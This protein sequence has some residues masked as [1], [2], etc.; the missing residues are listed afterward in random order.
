M[1]NTK[2]T[3]VPG[4]TYDKVTVT[5]GA[6]EFQGDVSI[7][8]L[9]ALGGGETFD[10]ALSIG[11]SQISLTNTTLTLSQAPTVAAGVGLSLTN[12]TLAWPMTS[13]TMLS[14]LSLTSRSKLTAVQATTAATYKL[15]LNVTGA[16][17][18]D[19]TSSIDVSGDGYLGGYEGSNSASAYGRTQ[20]NAL[21]T[22]AQAH[23][24]YGGY[25]SSATSAWVATYGD[26]K[27]P[28][29]LGSGGYGSATN[30]AGGA[31]GGLVRINAGSLVLNGQIL[32]DAESNACGYYGSGGGIRLD[33]G[34]L[35]GSGSIS[36]LGGY[37]YG[38]G[39]RVA[40]YYQTN[41]GFNFANVVASSQYATSSGG[42]AGT[43]FTK[44][45]TEAN[46][47]LVINDQG[48]TPTANY[49]KATPV[50]GG[51]YDKVTVTSGVVEFQGD[52]TVADL[53][54]QGGGET[55]DGALSIGNSQLNLT[56]STLTLNQAPTL[57]AGVGLN[58][59]NTTV[60][61]PMTITTALSSLSL[62]SRS[63]LTAVQATTASAYKLDL[64]VTGAVT[65]DSTSSIDVSGDGYLGGYE[66]SNSA[67][68]FGRT[69]ENALETV[70]RAH[71]S[72]GGYGESDTSAWVATYGD[73]KDPNDLGSGGFGNSAS[74]AG[75]A[76]GGL[77]RLVAGSLALNGQI[78]ANGEPSACA[79]YGSGGGIRLDV[80]TL[81]GSGSIGAL[82]GYYYGGGGRI[83]IYYQTNS[84]F[85]FTKVVAGSQYA[86]SSGG[87]AGTV[88]IKSAAETSGE[89]V[90]NDQGATP[91]ASYTKATP[92]LGG[93]YD[94]LTTSSGVVEVLSDVAISELEL[95]GGAQI[96][97]GA[98]TVG[99]TQ[100]AISSSKATFNGTLALPN[101]PDVSLTSSTISLAETAPLSLNSLTLA[102][103]STLTHAPATSEATY[104]LDLDVAG[105]VVIDSSSKIDVSG[106]GYLGGYAGDNQSPFGRTAGNVLDTH[107]NSGGAHGGNGYNGASPAQQAFDDYVD[108]SDFGGG[109][110]GSSSCA[111]GSG[112]GVIRIQS[113][114]LD[115]EGAL[116]A[117]G[118]G[119]CQG[120]GA[121]GTIKVV[122]GT[123]A[124]AGQAMAFG[125]YYTGAG[126]RISFT[127]Q[128]NQGFN[129]SNLSA[130]G[131]QYASSQCGG[132][133]TIYVKG[134]SSTFG[135]MRMDNGGSTSAAYTPFA[136]TGTGT[137]S[138]DN[139]YLS[140]GAW[141]TT[142]DNLS[143]SGTLQVDTS[144]HLT[145]N[146]MVR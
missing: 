97:E 66:R 13:T 51:A 21:E 135:D 107:A 55:F 120:N 133:G 73:L 104:R 117:E 82:G 121:G 61:W 48:A 6:V 47:E 123:L 142:P 34:T 111:G 129:I 68:A 46:G 57:A 43:V 102:S 144:S 91:G 69:Q 115:L 138:F 95:N 42:G 24:S 114:S 103:S 4:G 118:V 70:S 38:G 60:A 3:P 137:L 1:N 49:T 93:A 143:V 94:K 146:N 92:V 22:A 64:N 112:G 101:A 25:G 67:S 81:S 37:Y 75:G 124:G 86:T 139:L 110:A 52:V 58:L 2:P 32:A 89:L 99:N 23:G 130:Q 108:P 54:A 50:P 27:D 65:I 35:S 113:A 9:E 17:T 132:A 11:N 33:T 29:D 71:G 78:L 15:D 145:A 18:I 106:K 141:L 20:G 63:K 140:R 83:A 41:N 131:S 16:V 39:G 45:A 28:N 10:G 26:L 79:Y 62:T 119:N 53:E 88:F 126:G 109:G 8:D 5:S 122:T 31:G 36:A 134:P 44:S 77:V 80:G 96:F 105:A 87:G 100:L 30:C 128:S 12:T 59:T 74:C 90:I 40:I 98:A 85:D 14:S 116:L 19:S 56:N 76:G 72:Y 84:G 7:A 127:Y 136:P 125:S